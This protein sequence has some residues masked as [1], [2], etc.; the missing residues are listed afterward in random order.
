LGQL[1]QG[2]EQNLHG[3]LLSHTC[4]K[5]C[6]QLSLKKKF[7]IRGSNTT[8]RILGLIQYNHHYFS[9]LN[10]VMKFADLKT[11]VE[12]AF[13]LLKT[14]TREEKSS[15][16]EVRSSKLK[17]NSYQIKLISHKSTL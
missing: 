8:R 10:L 11:N 6:H 2:T 14:I 15:S 5:L 1:Y 9:D 13:L 12:G 16:T 17:Q 4:C 7:S 3:N